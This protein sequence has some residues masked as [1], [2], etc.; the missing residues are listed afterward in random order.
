MEE[1]K[2]KVDE[3]MDMGSGVYYPV[4]NIYHW[5]FRRL[6]ASKKKYF[7]P[8]SHP[9]ITLFPTHQRFTITLLPSSPRQKAE[10]VGNTPD[11]IFQGSDDRTQLATRPFPG[12][13]C[14]LSRSRCGKVH[15][16][17]T[18]EMRRRGKSQRL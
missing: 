15:L 2:K 8:G 3:K 12:V 1:E 18:V 5:I 9:P 11:T 4:S 7:N 14:D 17:R 10:R 16:V 13:Q 6:C